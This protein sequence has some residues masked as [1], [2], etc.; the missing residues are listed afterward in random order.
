[1]HSNKKMITIVAESIMLAER[2]PDLSDQEVFEHIE[3]V[4]QTNP[5]AANSALGRTII[6]AYDSRSEYTAFKT[7]EAFS[8]V[9]VG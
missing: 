8:G 9:T 7:Y 1:M 6:A 5:I 2:F 4:C 3:F